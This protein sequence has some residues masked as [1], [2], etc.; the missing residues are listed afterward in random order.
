MW[1][2]GYSMKNNKQ[3][4]KENFRMLIENDSIGQVEERLNVIDAFLSTEEHVTL[5]ELMKILKDRE[6]FS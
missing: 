3:F 1:R 5:E 2:L 6:H 4:E